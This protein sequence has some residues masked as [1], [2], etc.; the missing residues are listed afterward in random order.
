M[1]NSMQKT[2]EAHYI[3]CDARIKSFYVHVEY[4]CRD[5]DTKHA[6]ADGTKARGNRTEVIRQGFVKLWQ[7]HC[8]SNLCK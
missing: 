8:A 1:K 3:Y 5:D 4:Q 7:R 6:T 2:W